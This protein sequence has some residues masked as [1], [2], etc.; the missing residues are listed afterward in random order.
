[1]WLAKAHSFDYGKGCAVAAHNYGSLP[2]HACQPKGPPCWFCLG[3]RGCKARFFRDKFSSSIPS[4][5]AIF[6]RLWR[7]FLTWSAPSTFF[8]QSTTYL[9]HSFGHREEKEGCGA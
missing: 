6:C 8:P 2:R 5:S 4:L 7:A 9:F 3:R 1:M